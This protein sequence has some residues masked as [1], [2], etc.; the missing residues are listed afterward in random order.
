MSGQ[1][2]VAKQPVAAPPSKAGDGNGAAAPPS[3]PPLY[4]RLIPRV[5]R[6]TY[7]RIV[8]R[9]VRVFLRSRSLNEW[10]VFSAWALLQ[11]LFN[12]L[13]FGVVFFCV[14]LIGF[15]F[16]TLNYESTR[17]EGQL[18][19]Y[20][21]FNPD[22]QRLPGTYDPTEYERMLRAGGGLAGGLGGAK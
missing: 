7:R 11:L 16:A 17:K 9:L 22:N 6:S 19:A 18:S 1:R 21:V 8:P 2:G 12:R 10:L 20:S 4:V 13:E 3:P 5:V 14:S 15:V